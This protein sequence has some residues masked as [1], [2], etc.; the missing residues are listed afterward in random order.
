MKEYYTYIHL[1]PDTNAV[2][3][4][5]RG[6]GKRAYHPYNRN[7]HW[8]N[9]VKKNKGV[10]DVVIVDTDLTHLESAKKEI[11]LIA[12]YE[13]HTLTNL[14]DGG[15]G[16]NGWMPSEETRSKISNWHKGKVVSESTRQKI[17]QVVTGTIKGPRPEHVKQKISAANSGNGNGMFGRKITEEAKQ[18]QRDKLTG[19]Q[20]Y[21]AKPIINLQTGIFYDTLQQASDSIGIKRGTL[22]AMIAGRN[23]NKTSFI[24]A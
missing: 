5:G 21:L 12:F 16:N 22:W 10:F 1:R 7:R 20:N 6:K 18:K 17:S 4:V 23:N 9:V 2:F 11:E 14:S 15:E 24:Y 13:R 8:Q 3:Y 19:S